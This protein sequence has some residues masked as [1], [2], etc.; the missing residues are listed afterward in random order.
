MV[1]NVT[2]V[3]F[4]MTLLMNKFIKT[5]MD[6]GWVHSTAK[7]LPSLVSNLWC[8][9][10]MDDWN[11]DENLLSKW[12]YLQHCK[13]IIP[14]KNYKEWQIMLGWHSVL[15]HYTTIYNQLWARQLELVTID[16]IFNALGN[17]DKDRGEPTASYKW[18]T[19]VWEITGW[20]SSRLQENYR[21]W[22]NLENMPQM[23]ASVHHGW[24][25][26]TMVDGL[27]SSLVENMVKK[28]RSR[29]PIAVLLTTLICSY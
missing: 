1:F 22:R 19:W 15:W 9:I 23:G 10:I 28:N 4:R 24:W 18:T 12:Q 20:S 26:W 17:R 7:T 5:V 21:F 25:S 11:L 8:N 13:S 27:L 2:K 6:N 14:P 29:F 16:I 3:P